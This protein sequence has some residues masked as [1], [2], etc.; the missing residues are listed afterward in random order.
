MLPI[1]ILALDAF[2][3]VHVI[4]NGKTCWWI[5]IILV[6]PL[7]T[8]SGVE[9]HIFGPM[10]KTYAY[11]LAGGLLATFLVSPALSALM[12]PSQVS[13]HETFAVRALHHVYMPMLRFSVRHRAMTLGQPAQAGRHPAVQCKDLAALQAQIDRKTIRAP[14]RGSSQ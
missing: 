3:A 8:L 12:L 1:L 13:E 5:S 14:F 9:G 10:A 6:L 7:F 11:A 2:M 4:R